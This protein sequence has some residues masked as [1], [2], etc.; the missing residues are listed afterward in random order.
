[1][2]AV[3]SDSSFLGTPILQMENYSKIALSTVL[4]LAANAPAYHIYT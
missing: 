4:F 2:H 3:I 1:M